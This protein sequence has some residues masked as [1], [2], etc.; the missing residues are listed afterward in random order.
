MK[1]VIYD[2]TCGLCSRS[3]RLLI[4]LDTHKTFRYTSLQGKFVKTLPLNTDIDSIVFYDEGTLYYKSSAIL[5]I[6][7]S[8]GGFWN[9][10]TLFY[11]IPRFIRDAA[12]DVVAKYRYRFFKPQQCH[13]IS[14]QEQEL[15]LE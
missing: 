6:L 2:G 3:L 9:M 10:V 8:L 15:F 12:Y 1:I 4:K 13:M 7:R 11:V 5:K 14:V